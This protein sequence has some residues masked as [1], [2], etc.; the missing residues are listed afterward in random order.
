ML[1]KMK[2]WEKKWEQNKKTFT[3][4]ENQQR[5]EVRVERSKSEGYEVP[6]VMQ[7]RSI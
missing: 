4:K 6:G 5:W 1:G 2:I 3:M 7:A